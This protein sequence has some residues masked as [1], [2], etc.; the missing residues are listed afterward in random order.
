LIKQF[1]KWSLRRL[2]LELRYY[3]PDSSDEARFMANLSA[4]GINLVLDVGA[5]AGQFGRLI[6]S[7][8]Y[9]GRIV[10]FEPLSAARKLLEAEIRDDSLWQMAPQMAI[11]DE[12]GEIEIHIAGNSYSSSVLPMLDAH[13]SAAPDSAYVEREKVPLRRL[14]AVASGYLAPDAVLFLKIDTQG[15]EDRVL[16]GAAG[17]MQRTVGLQIEMSLVPLYEGQRLYVELDARLRALGFELWSLSPAFV[18]PRN[19]R[20]LQMDA[21]YFRA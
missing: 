7:A 4:H 2:G 6:R 3:L 5:N 16:Q 8:G 20:M 21:T 9:R 17:L 18:D 12:D 13:R 11:G 14:D 10:S 15:Y 1:I 19:G